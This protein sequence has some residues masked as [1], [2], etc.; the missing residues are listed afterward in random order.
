MGQAK[1]RREAGIYPLDRDESAVPTDLQRDIAEVVRSVEFTGSGGGNCVFRALLGLMV[2]RA[3]GLPAQRC[4]GGM[5]YRTGPH[6]LRDVVA[7]CGPDN[8]GAIVDGGF[9]G[10]SWLEYRGDLIDF[11]CGD[12]RAEAT[13]LYEWEREISQRR[14]VP[15]YGEIQWDA[16]PPEYIWQRAAPLRNA[17]RRSGSPE[18]GRFWYGPCTAEV[19]ARTDY[20]EDVVEI[21]RTGLRALRP[22]I[23]DLQLI[24]RARAVMA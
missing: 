6:P 8:L 2:M 21:L 5:V 13:V 17:W 11:S 20:G 18:L 9:I 14:G 22:M 15:F 23:S 16:P 19:G 4:V 24:Q 7:F 1:L 12:W 10:H 3:I